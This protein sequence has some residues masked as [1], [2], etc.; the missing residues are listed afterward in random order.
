MGGVRESPYLTNIPKNSPAP[1]LVIP[2]RQYVNRKTGYF[3]HGQCSAGACPPLRPAT[4]RQPLQRTIRP[5]NK[6]QRSPYLPNTRRRQQRISGKINLEEHM[7]DTMNV[8]QKHETAKQ[9][10]AVQVEVHTCRKKPVFAKQTPRDTRRKT[11]SRR[12]NLF[13]QNKIDAST[14]RYPVAGTRP[15]CR[16]IS[17]SFVLRVGPRDIARFRDV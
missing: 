16:E 5:P 13:L 11:G 2:A 8:D 7:Y 12:K 3:Y 6:H 4:R 1:H 15:R 10:P 14:E 17:N 9:I